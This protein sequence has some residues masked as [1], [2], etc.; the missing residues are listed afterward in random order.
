M[1]KFKNEELRNALKRFEAG[2]PGEVGGIRIGAIGNDG[3]PIDQTQLKIDFIKGILDYAAR[4]M[5]EAA[6]ISGR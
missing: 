3:E 4:I 2:K 1:I 6:D 5:G